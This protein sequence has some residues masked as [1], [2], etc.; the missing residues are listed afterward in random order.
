MVSKRNIVLF[1]F[2]ALA[3]A[4][5]VVSC[6]RGEKSKAPQE[7]GASVAIE[8]TSPAFVAG[9][10]L[11]AKY[12]C[13]GENVS[14]PLKWSGIPQDAQ[15]LALLCEDPDATEGSRVL[16]LVYN[17]PPSV[18]ELTEAGPAIGILPNGAK[19]GTNDFKTLGY[20]GPCPPPG[21]THRCMF[22][23]YALDDMPKLP[24]GI[25]KKD[26][27]NAMERHHLAERQLMATC[28]KK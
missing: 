22:K 9:A 19:Q 4:F 11:P 3:V 5:L 26:L 7:K 13:D 8:L 17:I 10:P 15:S 20:T 1:C 28:Q 6:S 24:P 25:S 21:K 12:T 18:A 27:I 23:L 14:P 2:V 16:W